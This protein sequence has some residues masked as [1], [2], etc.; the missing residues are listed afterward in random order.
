M[1]KLL[2]AAL[3]GALSTT[4]TL[5]VATNALAAT[6]HAKKK[7]TRKRRTVA[8]K[9]TIPEGSVQW[10]CMDK[11]SFWLKGDAAHDQ[12]LTLHW[13]NKNYDL[14]R[15]A[16]TTGANRF[17]DKVSGFDLIVLPGK[18]MLLSDHS[19]ERLADECKTAAMLQ[20]E[21]AAP[22]GQQAPALQS[23]RVPVQ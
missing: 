7:I 10:S 13:V 12:T 4:L 23:Q 11:Q 18:A 6:K 1:K 19:G 21:R 3:I 17:G 8:K 22:Q 9:V 20:G 14:L 15:V 2:I 16:T 5:G